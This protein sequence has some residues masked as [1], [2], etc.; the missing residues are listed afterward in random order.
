MENNLVI[1]TSKIQDVRQIS[2]VKHSMYTLL[3]S[4]IIGYLS[5][6]NDFHEV[7][8]LLNICK[9]KLDKYLHFHRDAENRI[10]VPS[11]DTIERMVAALDNKV[12][13]ET[14]KEWYL[15]V[16]KADKEI[17]Q[18]IICIDGKTMRGSRK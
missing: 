5:N 8:E 4:I 10:I 3:G 17:I 15:D 13:Q 11:H 2:K 6:C 1:I 16:S 9:D 7:N 14:L 18:K 12:L